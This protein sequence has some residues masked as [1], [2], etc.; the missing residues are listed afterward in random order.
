MAAHQAA[1]FDLRKGFLMYTDEN[2]NRLIDEAFKSAHSEIQP[3][4]SWEALRA[5]I[6]EKIGNK[7]I[8]SIGGRNVM[9]WRRAALVMAA[10]FIITSALLIY[11]LHNIRNVQE[12][13]GKGV[14]N[15]VQLYQLSTA[16]SQVRRL[17]NDQFPWQL[18]GYHNIGRI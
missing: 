9:F 1:G 16:F 4:D 12:Q 3:R 2:K 7:V 17:F 5:R 11:V 14:L 6:D 18:T 13:T 8:S 10:C 15:Q